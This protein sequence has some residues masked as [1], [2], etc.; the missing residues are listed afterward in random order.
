MVTRQCRT[1][2]SRDPCIF[3]RFGQIIFG[4]TIYVNSVAAHAADPL[5]IPLKH[6]AAEY[7]ADSFIALGIMIGVNESRPKLYQFDTGSDLFIGQFDNN[8]PGVEPSP[9]KQA[10]MYTYGDGSYGYW[11]Q[12]IQFGQMSYYHPDEPTAPVVTIAGAHVAGKIL[13]WAYSKEYSGFKDTRVSA[14][15]VGSSDGSLFY[16]DLDVRERIKNGEPSDHPP[17]YGTFGAGNFTGNKI[18]S[19]APGSQIRTGYVIAA[20]ANIGN[21][22]TP[23][24]APCLA[25]HLTPALRAQFTALMPWGELGYDTYQRKFSNSGA[26]ASNQ[27]E[28]N[29]DYVI[30]VP[31]GK[32]KRKVEFNSPILLDTGTAEFILVDTDTLLKRLHDKGFSLS[33]HSEASVDIK[34]GSFPDSFNN[35]EYG[36][37]TMRRLADEDEGNALTI[38]LPFFQANSVMYDLQNRITA[39]S[40]FFVTVDNFTTDRED[41]RLGYLGR[42]SDAM[43][44]S[45]WI[46]LAG[47][48][49][50]RGDF[51][52]EKG[53][54]AWVTGA[55]TYTGATR[56]AAGSALYLSGPG[57]IEHSAHILVE[58][59]LYIKHKGAYFDSWGVDSSTED[60]I[61][62]NI[63]G[64]GSVVLG[65][66][67]LILTAA[68]GQ[69]DGSLTDKDDEGKN[70]GGGFVL[71][72]GKL[73]LSGENDYS[74]L[75]EIANNAEL[76][77]TGSLTGDVAVYGKLVVD[78]NVSGTVKVHKGGQLSGSGTIG[79]LDVQSGGIATR[80]KAVVLD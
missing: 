46:G 43:G 8:V 35:L 74:G 75:T 70:S 18:Y 59:E 3:A 16:A 73:I 20:N 33:E 79:I 13:D 25:M 7:D 28:G 15:P 41:Q 72:G 78:G 42:I 11:M 44:S 2:F 10:E 48:L 51:I 17:F 6:I 23:G 56:I 40:P 24:C 77:L 68:N 52:L 29:Y 53:V 45:G 14:K 67:R 5:A 31:V 47:S 80:M 27:H 61:I 64:H 26:N 37:V 65:T 71:A 39:Y 36:N 58:G 57:T 76:H 66:R 34:L 21:H 19:A 4:I 32:K 38:G 50:G 69:F 60:T 30:S 49:S 1:A 63:K 9:H 62:Q 55:N 22:N 12:E 54:N